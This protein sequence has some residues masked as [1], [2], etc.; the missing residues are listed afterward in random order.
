MRKISGSESHRTKKNSSKASEAHRD[1]Q[2]GRR[3]AGLRRK[4]HQ[5]TNAPIRGRD[6]NYIPNEVSVGN[7]QTEL[8]RE[9]TEG[10][11]IRLKL[12]AFV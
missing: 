11:K 8:E 9:S 10:I 7:A 4:Q 6:I 12:A 3:M 2:R 1:Q 5:P